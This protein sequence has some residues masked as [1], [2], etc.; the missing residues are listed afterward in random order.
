MQ[1]FI[2]F[3]NNFDASCK[4]SAAFGWYFDIISKIFINL[5]LLRFSLVIR[6]SLNTSSA[7][8]VALKLLIEVLE[9]ILFS[10]FY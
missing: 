9:K 10:F 1:A 5:R 6:N 4:C 2:Y 8:N 3:S 7:L